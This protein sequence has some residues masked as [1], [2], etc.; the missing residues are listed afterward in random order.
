MESTNPAAL[1][2]CVQPLDDDDRR[3][4]RRYWEQVIREEWVPPAR[5]VPRPVPV[6]GDG[7][8][9]RRQARRAVARIAAATR[10]GQ[11]HELPAASGD[12]AA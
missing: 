2:E 3:A 12:E 1:D 11:R 6:A 4:V 10:T 5:W 8:R 9:E 7:R